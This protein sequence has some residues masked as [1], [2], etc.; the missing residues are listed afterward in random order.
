MRRG[1]S[2]VVAFVLLAT[3]GVGSI[4]AAALP[5]ADTVVVYLVRHAEKFDDSRDPPLSE[6][7]KTRAAEL[8]R[9]LADAGVTHVWSTNLERTRATA[10]PTAALRGLEVQLY[11]PNDLPGFATRLA[12]L[13]GR[14]LVV[15]HSNTTPAL[16]RALGGNPGN[17]IADSEYDR[18]YILTLGNPAPVTVLLRFGA[19]ASPSQGVPK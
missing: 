1:L 11:D 5:A 16:V 10:A 9:L 18:C 14:H 12:S 15:G 13:P 2:V 19:D 8:A 4:R 17:L 3:V 6:A 7:G